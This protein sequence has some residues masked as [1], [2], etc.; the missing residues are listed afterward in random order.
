MNT[1]ITFDLEQ[2]CAQ[3]TVDPRLLRG[4]EMEAVKDYI[5]GDL[6]YRLSRYICSHGGDVL[7]VPATWWDHLKLAIREKPW[8]PRWLVKFL[9]VNRIY[10]EAREYVPDV[11]PLE[12]PFDL[13]VHRW[14]K[15]SIA[16]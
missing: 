8:C 16:Q 10:H 9:K 13:R 6:V 1:H 7:S 11:L 2:V 15:L 3:V 14:R 5:T 12:P 4:A